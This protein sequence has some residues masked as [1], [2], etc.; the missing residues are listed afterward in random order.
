[1]RTDREVRI[2]CVILAAG[3]AARF[4]SNKLFAEIDGKTMIERAFEAIPKE[5]L[6]GVIVVTQYDDAVRLAQSCG[7]EYV[8]NT[9]PELGLSRSVRLGTE[10]LMDRCDGI[11]YLVAD[12]PRLT[13]GSVDRMLEVFRE[14]PERIVSLGSGG[15]R[16]NPCIFPKRFFGELC[17]LSGD[18]GG[19]AVIERHEDSSVLVEVDG[20][21]LMDVDFPEDLPVK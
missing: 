14:N 15:R 2:G 10:A 5:N 12:Q 1:M 7:F 6:C 16:G 18:R 11:L 9:R 3:N 19:R 20:D 21:E 4:G 17:R 13:R 8:I